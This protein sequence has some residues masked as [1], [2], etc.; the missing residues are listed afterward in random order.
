[1]T[2]AQL[3]TIDQLH[4]AEVWELGNWWLLGLIVLVILLLHWKGKL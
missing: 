4:D 1:M 2:P 3:A